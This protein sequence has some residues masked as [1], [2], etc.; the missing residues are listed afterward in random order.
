M[1]TCFP[2]YLLLLQLITDLFLHWVF[3]AF[4]INST[5]NFALRHLYDIKLSILLFSNHSQKVFD[6]EFIQAWH[7]WILLEMAFFCLTLWASWSHTD[8][9]LFWSI[10][11]L[12]G[13]HLLVLSKKGRRTCIPE[14]VWFY[15]SSWVLLEFYFVFIFKYKEKFVIITTF[16]TLLYEALPLCLYL[17]SLEACKPS[18]CFKIFMTIYQGPDYFYILCWVF[19]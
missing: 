13:A 15:S 5:L 16:L 9:F 6:F 2:A 19:L 14:N 7:P 12:R 17:S 1:I 18:L 8:F 4:I 10:T 3:Y 11:F